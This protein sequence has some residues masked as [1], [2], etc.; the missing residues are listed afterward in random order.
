MAGEGRIRAA[1]YPSAM[2][3]R[4]RTTAAPVPTQL[5]IWTFNGYQPVE[6]VLLRLPCTSEGT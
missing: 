1:A 5:A 6:I 3:A 4:Y 2:Q